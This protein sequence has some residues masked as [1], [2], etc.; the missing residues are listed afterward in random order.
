LCNNFCGV[1]FNSSDCE[2]DRGNLGILEDRKIEVWFMPPTANER[3]A[4]L[5]LVVYLCFGN[6]FL[7]RLR[8]SLKYCTVLIRLLSGFAG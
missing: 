5:K 6:K 8:C 1:A 4:L 2:L 7:T 3:I